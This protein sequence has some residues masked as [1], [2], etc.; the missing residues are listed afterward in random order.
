MG[1]KNCAH[2]GETFQFGRGNARFCSAECRA[3]ATK[4]R[5]PEGEQ[6]CKVEGCDRWR[7]RVDPGYCHKHHD[8]WVN[9]GDPLAEPRRKRRSE[10]P[11]ELEV[12]WDGVET[13]YWTKDPTRCPAGHEYTEE[14]TTYRRARRD[15]KPRRICRTCHRER[16]HKRKSG[17]APDRSATCITCGKTWEASKF[18]TL[19]RFCVE[20]KLIRHRNKTRLNKSKKRGQ[21]PKG[22]TYTCTV[23][24]FVAP[25]PA[26]SGMPPKLCDAC[27]ASSE[28]ESKRKVWRRKVLDKYSLTA[29]QFAQLVE[30]Q[31]CACAVC[32]AT[33][34]GG[35]GAWHV[36][37]DHACCAEGRSCG[38]C[39][40]G[41]L[42]SR[43]NSGLGLFDDDSERLAAALAYLNDPP[44]KQVLNR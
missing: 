12:D 22:P 3:A 35:A 44:A 20:C 25:T 11:V 39:V 27:Q 34:P 8:R 32:G 37:H 24:G 29:E 23:C 5:I 17:E 4:S 7:S 1:T 40:R 18:G 38:K 31:G 19:P 10:K 43:C 14:N 26:T 16:Y 41:L 15:G 21:V 30:S 33:E 13:S 2:C 42:C 28:L 9:Y 36:D 6:K